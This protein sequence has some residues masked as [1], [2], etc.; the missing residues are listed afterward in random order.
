MVSFAQTL[1]CQFDE[2]VF[3]CGLL[4]VD[5]HQFKS[6]LIDPLDESTSVV[7]GRREITVRLASASI[8]LSMASAQLGCCAGIGFVTGHRDCR[9][10][11]ALLLQFAGVSIAMMR[12]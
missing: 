10:R 1:S 5:I 2:H 8:M 3:Q 4:Q 12:P 9:C 7:A 6:A 11:A